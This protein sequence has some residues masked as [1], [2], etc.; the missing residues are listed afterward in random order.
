MVLVH[1]SGPNDRDETVGLTKCFRDLAWGLT[2]RGIAVLRY[3]KRTFKYGNKFT[4]ELLES[5]TINEE[6]IEDAL[7]AIKVMQDY[8]GISDVYL[9]G[10][11]L[12]ATMAPRIG[13]FMPSLAGLILMAAITRPLEDVI[14]DQSLIFTISR[15]LYHQSRGVN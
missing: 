3:D 7:S 14:L 11:S 9:L 13:E 2:S 15:V 10:H 6:V 1:G 5:F 8:P 12:G 4:P